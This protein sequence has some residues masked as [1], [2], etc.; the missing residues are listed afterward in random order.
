LGTQEFGHQTERRRK[1]VM[2]FV[3][4]GFAAV[5]LVIAG[6]RWKSHR[7]EKAVVVPKPLPSN[8]S[9]QLSG[10]SFTR[11][12]NR[13][14]IF[15]VR[16]SRTV[17]FQGDETVLNDVSVEVFGK[18]G[19]QH[20]L[21]R[22]R[23]CDYNRKTGELF[24]EGAVEIELNAPPN[25]KPDE[26]PS[27]FG[28]SLLPGPGR[29]IPQKDGP[30]P[31]YLETSHLNFVRQGSLVVTHAPVKFRAGNASGTALGLTYATRDEWVELTKNVVMEMSA[32]RGGPSSAPLRL[33]ADRL[34]FEKA[35]GTVTLWGP[36]EI[37][38]M[39]KRVTAASGKVQLDARNRVTAAELDGDVKAHVPLR[40][41]LIEG[42]AGRAIAEFDPENSQVRLIRAEENVQ[43]AS[44]GNGKVTRLSAQRL[45]LD[46][47]G[48]PARPQSGIAEGDV[49]IASEATHAAKPG[50]SGATAPALSLAESKQD[51]TASAV[52]FTFVPGGR[53]LREAET[54]GPGKMI[55]V[56]NNPKSGPRVITANPFVLDFDPQG[57][58]A[59]MRGLADARMVFMPAPTAPAGTPN[60]VTTS[61]KFLAT[62]GPTGRTL[63]AIDQTGDFRFEQGQQ[64]GYAQ[65]AHYDVSSEITT[66]TG[67]PRL[68]DEET[69]AQADRIL[70]NTD[71]GTAEG[72]GR[73]QTSH[74]EKS[75]K[76]SKQEP[77]DPTNVVADR[78]LAKRQSQFVHYEGNVRVWHG[79]DIVQSAAID[80][81]KGERRVR[82]ESRVLTSFL[83]PA[84]ETKG[85]GAKAG[86]TGNGQAVPVTIRA[87]GLEYSDEDRKATYLGNVQLDTQDATLRADRMDVFFLAPNQSGNS[88]IERAL[89]QGN[90]TV[91][92]PGR[93]ATGDRAEYFA[94]PDKIILSGGPPT[95]YDTERGFTTGRQLTFFLRDDRIFLDGG[96]QSPT[97]S[98]HRIP[99]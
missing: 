1:R 76:T 88:E 79:A 90:V 4:A 68:E 49:R 7:S 9:Q 85:S 98:I 5:L 86:K 13:R 38:Q 94:G 66:L 60:A 34:R 10:Y 36:V 27:D 40:Q 33:R 37:T 97:L 12:D 6:Y 2:R 61:E 11:S 14:Q 69:R 74:L 83:Q 28:S 26:F 77:T 72:L 25:A 70:L 67:Q 23:A 91:V 55:L 51:L 29:D 18:S 53:M 81:F 87:D 62:F 57:R 39:D 52:R 80:V 78:M 71:T 44:A 31:V 54:V 3:V 93:R 82:T 32:Q 48:E 22:T 99:Q 73:V 92:Q 50:N 56:S 75:S 15:T 16:A 47:L 45:Q 84:R 21:I 95:I 24:A 58:P 43:A 41:S 30:I 96:D 35:T 64:R 17:A 89:A 42:S 46:F 59:T 20:D 8:V 65:K 63:R 19:N